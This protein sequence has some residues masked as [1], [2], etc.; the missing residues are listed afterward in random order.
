[1]IAIAGLV[2]AVHVFFLQSPREDVDARDKARARR[3][4]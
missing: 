2:P 1:M 3:K 4:T